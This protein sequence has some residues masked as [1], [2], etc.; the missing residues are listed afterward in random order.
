[1]FGFK[2]GHGIEKIESDISKCGQEI[3]THET[4]LQDIQARLEQGYI[5]SVTGEKTLTEKQIKELEGQEQGETRRIAALKKYLD[6]LRAKQQR[7]I[8]DQRQERLSEVRKELDTLIK[9]TAVEWGAKVFERLGALH[10]AQEF[11]NPARFA[12]G[13][14]E[15]PEYK[16]AYYQGRARSR[17]EL[18]L[19]QVKPLY[20]QRQELEAELRDLQSGVTM[21]RENGRMDDAFKKLSEATQKE[22]TEFQQ[23]EA[24]AEAAGIAET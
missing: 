13:P 21:N 9:S 2:K 7:A 23:M 18:G 10:E 16:N 1:M 19:D 24:R 17:R 15:K 4:N 6:E 22:D 8:E 20:R 11:T 14:F 5:Q 12:G 3:A